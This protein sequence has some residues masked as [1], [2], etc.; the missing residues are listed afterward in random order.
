M[1]ADKPARCSNIAKHR[2]KH[3]P[4]TSTLDRIYPYQYA[5]HPH[6]LLANLVTDLVA[7]EG[8]FHNHPQRAHSL[9][10]LPKAPLL[11][12]SVR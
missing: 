4:I 10:H 11:A 7:I 6:E 12:I 2:V 1:G 8:G 3:R 9:K 5:V